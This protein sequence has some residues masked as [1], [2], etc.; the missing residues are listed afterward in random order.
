MNQVSLARL[1]VI[2][3]LVG[4]TLDALLPESAYDEYASSGSGPRCA[5]RSSGS[6]DGCRAD[7]YHEDDAS[8]TRPAPFLFGVSSPPLPKLN[9][10][11]RLSKKHP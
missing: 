10:G 5:R 1:T 4:A 2:A 6:G 11:K 3:A 8:G 9:F 7:H